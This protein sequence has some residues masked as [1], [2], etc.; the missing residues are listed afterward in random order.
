[1]VGRSSG[2]RI[3]PETLAVNICVDAD[4]AEGKVVEGWVTVGS[5]VSVCVA[6]VATAI[7]GGMHELKI[8]LDTLRMEKMDNHLFTYVYPVRGLA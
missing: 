6:S 7:G 4:V 5:G 8:K 3:V 1:M 2:T